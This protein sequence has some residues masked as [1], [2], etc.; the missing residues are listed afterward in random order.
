[1]AAKLLRSEY[2]Q[3]PE[4]VARFLQERTI[5]IGLN[6][7]NIV[8]VHDLVVEG[9]DLAI[10][11]DLVQAGSLNDYLKKSG[12]VAPAVA[13]PL[14]A[15]L[16][17]ALAYA[18]ERRILHRDIK[19]DNVLLADQ[20]LPTA[21]TVRLSD[22]GIARLTQEGSAVAASGL[23]GT[24]LY[25]PPELY[26]HG[27]FSPKSDV[28]ATGVVL[29]ELLAGRTPFA[30]PGTALTIGRRHVES[31]PPPLP[32]HPALWQT[33]SDLL[34]KDP[35]H[36]PSASEAAIRLHELTALD[37]N[38]LPVQPV[39]EQWATSSSLLPGPD[40]S[41]QDS[42]QSASASLET[43]DPHATFVKAGSR[44]TM[45]PATPEA[46]TAASNNVDPSQTQLKAAVHHPLTAAL[47]KPEV[48]STDR[49]K[50]AL[51]A[52]GAGAGVLIITLFVLWLTGVIS[53]G[54]DDNP[55]S[56]QTSAP[57]ITAAPAWSR[58]EAL[59]S[60]LS[61]DWSASYDAPSATTRLELT[62]HAP[63]STGLTGDV[64]FVLP[65]FTVDGCAVITS[66]PDTIE[67]VTASQDG[68]ATNC[69]YKLIDVNLA[70]GQN[71]T[72][73]LPI[74]GG[75]DD[76]Y[77]T[78]LSA[79]TQATDD[80]LRSLTGTSFPLQ[81]VTGLTVEA[82]SVALN[83]SGGIGQNVPY[84]VMAKWL[85]DHLAVPDY[86]LFTS[87]TLV[88]METEPLKELTGGLGLSAVQ[89]TPCSAA[90]N[91][92]GPRVRALQPVNSCSLTVQIGELTGE[93]MFS[94]DLNS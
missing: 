69:G 11:M 10:V 84:R 67:P 45:A 41:G 34:A 81:R 89:V 71:Q 88:G 83:Q 14:V 51:I 17:E 15:A 64:L 25:M 16:L 87:D 65:A 93:G 48:S 49:R 43:H 31:L 18:H 38:P 3:D 32:L 80:T 24:P 70:A 44:P 56:D 2:V 30:G 72:F 66:L 29:Y 73:V 86:V 9:D 74:E 79:I 57:Q 13:V 21:A 5:L 33:L 60:G 28:Y 58:G 76:N 54:N 1:L 82:D 47:P 53:P 46:S 36:R 19:P 68:V 94:V 7:P 6:H 62:A 52:G 23:I 22:F 27:Q 40:A 42:G 37:I 90:D 35:A 77:E 85:G 61:L 91:V 50:R 78:W 8:Q 92:S 26:E 39:P 55:S 59:A 12:T 75:P 63:R 4:I 20:G